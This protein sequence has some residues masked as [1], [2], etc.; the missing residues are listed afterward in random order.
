MM[1]ASTESWRVENLYRHDRERLFGTEEEFGV[2]S[3]KGKHAGNE[4]P[5]GG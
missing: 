1:L 3:D 5:K 2:E 4:R